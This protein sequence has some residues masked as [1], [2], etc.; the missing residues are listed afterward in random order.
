MV[1]VIG[2][3]HC[4]MPRRET[5]SRTVHLS[6]NFNEIRKKYATNLHYQSDVRTNVEMILNNEQLT[7]SQPNHYC[8]V[9]CYR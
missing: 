7:F 5:N 8:V 2:R 3:F 9:V 4:S 1:E 6:K